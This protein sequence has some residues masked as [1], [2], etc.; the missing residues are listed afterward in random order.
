MIGLSC[1]TL[2]IT[3]DRTASSHA[4]GENVVGVEGGVHLDLGGV[5]VGLVFVGL[6]VAVVSRLDDGIEQ[7]REN[8][9]R[10]LVSRYRADGHDEGVA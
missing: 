9:V 4:G 5:E 3:A 10:L 7:V 2:N 6:L 1:E 8:L